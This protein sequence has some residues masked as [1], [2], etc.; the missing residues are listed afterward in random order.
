MI[1]DLDVN[2]NNLREEAIIKNRAMQEYNKRIYDAKHK[3]PNVYNIGDYVMIKN[4]ITTP[5]VNQKL[6]PKYY[7]T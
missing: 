4:V 6:V 7:N 2:R 3:K 1:Q 5:G